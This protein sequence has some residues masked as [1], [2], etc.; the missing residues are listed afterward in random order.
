MTLATGSLL[1]FLSTAVMA[2]EKATPSSARTLITSDIAGWR[3]RPA[4][5]QQR[6]AAVI[7]EAVRPAGRDQSH[8]ITYY[9]PPRT[10]AVTV[11]EPESARWL[12]HEVQAHFR[13]KAAQCKQRTAE[14]KKRLPP[15]SYELRTLFGH[16]V[17]FGAD[18]EYVWI[19][20]TNRVVQIGWGRQLDRRP[21]GTWETF[22]LPEEFLTTYLRLLPSSLPDIRFDEA[23]EQQ[24]VRDAFDRDFEHVAYYLE[25]WKA[26]GAVAGQDEYAPASGRLRRLRDRRSQYFGGDDSKEWERKLVARIDQKDAAAQREAYALTATYAFWLAQYDELKAWWDQ[27]RTD[28]IKIRRR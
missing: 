11:E 6:L 20:G 19:S 7:G 2:S 17:F 9:S 21:D 22:E 23:H 5:T 26:H 24:Y 8:Y 16:R 1:L 13:A 15:Y 27:H 18:G 10:I 28:P 3:A 4:F 12:L 25:Q 14:E